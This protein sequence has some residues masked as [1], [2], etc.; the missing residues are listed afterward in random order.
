M[1]F[2]HSLGTTL[3]E[4]CL[5]IGTTGTSTRFLNESELPK[6]AEVDAAAC[7]NADEAAG[8]ASAPIR[9]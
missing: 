8:P 9:P 1:E 6:S 7:P 4:N 5:R 3:Q 2:I